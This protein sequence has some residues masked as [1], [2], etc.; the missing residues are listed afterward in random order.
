MR[1]RH[2]QI[3]IDGNLYAVSHLDS[4]VASLVGKGR[5]PGSDLNIE[6]V[7]SCHT[8]TERCLNGESPNITDHRGNARRFC[9]IRHAHSNMLPSLIRDALLGDII[10]FPTQDYNAAS[11]L[12]I[13]DLNG[14]M[15]Y[16]V[17]YHFQPSSRPN[18]D[19]T[20]NVVSAYER[21]AVNRTKGNKISYFARQCMF[22]SK[23][24][25]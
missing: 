4:F 16:C 11:N 12:S 20:M 19:V 18:T 25:P 2:T 5:S 1:Q 6:I 13:F 7:I 23:K 21:Q 3:T 24:V 15:Q 22:Q 9:K 17:I 10:T 14:G 8:Y